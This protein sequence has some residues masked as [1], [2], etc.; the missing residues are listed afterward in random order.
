MCITCQKHPPSSLSGMEH[1]VWISACLKVFW[2][3]T[4]LFQA[5]D[6]RWEEAFLWQLSA[7]RLYSHLCSPPPRRSRPERRVCSGSPSAGGLR[8]DAPHC[9]ASAPRSSIHSTPKGHTVTLYTHTPG[10]SSSFK[11]VVAVYFKI[12]PK[13]NKKMATISGHCMHCLSLAMLVRS[14][15]YL[16]N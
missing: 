8:S 3:W 4:Y 10:S 16:N 7:S 15:Q 5:V 14:C 9:R 12:H 13:N 6:W 2:Q 1:E 11:H